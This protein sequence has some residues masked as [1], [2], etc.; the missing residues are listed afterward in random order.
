MGRVSLGGIFRENSNIL[1]VTEHRYPGVPS[2]SA[3]DGRGH[4][5]GHPGRCQCSLKKN[6]SVTKYSYWVVI[7]SSFNS[8]IDHPMTLNLKHI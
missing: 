5:F 4:V 1:T 8:M 3:E 7:I 2:N 6:N